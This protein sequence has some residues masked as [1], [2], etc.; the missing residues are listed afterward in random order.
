MFN[1]EIQRYIGATS[2]VPGDIT[3]ELRGADNSTI[4]QTGTVAGGLSPTGVV[5]TYTHDHLDYGIFWQYAEFDNPEP[6][7]G[8]GAELIYVNNPFLVVGY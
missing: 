5:A 4:L 2:N 7:T 6:T 1:H 3:Y 8:P